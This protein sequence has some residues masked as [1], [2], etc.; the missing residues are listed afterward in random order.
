M[1]N[2]SVLRFHRK[3][4]LIAL[5]VAFGGGFGVSASAQIAFEDVSNPA[6]FGGSGSETW[7]A[8]WGDVDGDHYPDI[9]I[10]NHRTRAALYRNNR[11]R[12]FTDVS[13][14][15][16][17]SN[18]P[19]WTGGRADVDMHGAAWG[20]VDN[21]GDDDLI[22]SVSSGDDYIFINDNGLLTQ[23]NV[24]YGLRLLRHSA[25]RQN[26]FLDYNGDGRLDLAN[27]SLNRPAFSP[28]LANKTFGA[29]TTYEI[30][31]SC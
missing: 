15:V 21:D 1:S 26:L 13:H 6:G 14:Q 23:E 10:N 2:A 16:D 7:G 12:T 29:G 17:L 31:I 24:Q 11:D 30:P 25:T 5:A 4:L 9:Y 3:Q 18:T 8:A 20:D 22:Q 19:G 27:I 28:Q